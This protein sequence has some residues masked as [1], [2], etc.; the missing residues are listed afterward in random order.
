MAEVIKNPP[1]VDT[2]V[3]TDN[4]TQVLSNAINPDD[5]ATQT[6]ANSVLSTSQNNDAR[7]ENN[8]SENTEQISRII[9]ENRQKQKE[10]EE[11]DR[12]NKLIMETE[13][14]CNKEEDKRKDLSE[15][16]LSKKKVSDNIK[17][18]FLPY[19][20]MIAN[21]MIMAIPFLA[22]FMPFAAFAIL[23]YF[24]CGALKSYQGAVE[25]SYISTS[26]KINDCIA[27]L[28]VYRSDLK[29]LNEEKENLTTKINQANEENSKYENMQKEINELKALTNPML[30]HPAPRPAM[31]TAGATI[32]NPSAGADM[33]MEM[34]VPPPTGKK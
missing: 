33:G 5:L 29:R 15:E 11:I 14:K 3:D 34:P 9:N 27:N 20:K 23:A 22:V 4:V 10:R 2:D 13:A 12:L 18:L 6:I 24:A 16:L 28:G 30:P 25:K 17:N 1:P 8:N 26:N 32:A 7:Q 21:V 19:A 31:A